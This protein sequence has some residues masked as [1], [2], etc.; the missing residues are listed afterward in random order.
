MENFIFQKMLEYDAEWIFTVTALFPVLWLDFWTGN[1]F[2][3]SKRSKWLP[4][5]YEAVHCGVGFTQLGIS[6]G[7]QR[8]GFQSACNKHFSL[9]IDCCQG[10][11]DEPSFAQWFYYSWYFPRPLQI[12]F[13]LPRVLQ[14]VCNLWSIL[15]PHTAS[16]NEKWPY[17]GGFSGAVRPSVQTHTGEVEIC[18]TLEQS[19]L[20]LILVKIAV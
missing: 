17:Y 16:P 14:S 11:L 2:P 8:Q 10:S 9:I 7:V 19:L 18:S 12:H 6:R 13:G 4:K 5:C 1:W 15:L 20:K 3:N